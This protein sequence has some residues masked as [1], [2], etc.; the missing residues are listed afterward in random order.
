[1]SFALVGWLLF[2]NPTEADLIVSGTDTL[3]SPA[4]WTNQN[5]GRTDTIGWTVTFPANVTV[6]WVPATGTYNPASGGSASIE[7]TMTITAN[8]PDTNPI[9]IGF[10]QVPAGTKNNPNPTPRAP[11][12][13]L[14][15]QL[16]SVN[17]NQDPT[18]GWGSF[19]MKLVDPKVQPTFDNTSLDNQGLHPSFPHFHG[20]GTPTPFN[21]VSGSD[22][23]NKGMGFVNFGNDGTVGPTGVFDTGLI[24]VH[25]F[26]VSGLARQFTL[27]LQ[28]NTTFT[29]PPILTPEPSTLSLLLVLA[30]VVALIGTFRKGIE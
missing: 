2:P 29:Q 4:T 6:D 11:G 15:F 8:F 10:Q 30:G 1:M 14:R 12:L 21:F 16:D 18:T 13:G 9:S 3:A 23:G 28:P 22:D 20:K 24:G 27:V 17:S 5:A 7:G 25:D 26:E 19:A